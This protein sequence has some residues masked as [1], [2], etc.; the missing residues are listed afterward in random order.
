MKIG[1]SI[2]FKFQMFLEQLA[3]LFIW[4]T[5]TKNISDMYIYNVSVPP[6]KMRALNTI[7]GNT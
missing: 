6:D 2:D 7:R 4:T 5:P 3:I 1:D